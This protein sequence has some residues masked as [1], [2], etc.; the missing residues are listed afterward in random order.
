[1]DQPTPERRKA[2]RHRTLRG[3]AI[4]LYHVGTIAECTVRNLSSL[5][6]CLVVANDPAGVPS[7]FALTI[8]R[9]KPRACRVV[10]RSANKIGV[11][12]R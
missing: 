1:M 4:S 2:A 6:A 8:D 9:E 5:G 11:A 3:G 10:W 7:E 12:F